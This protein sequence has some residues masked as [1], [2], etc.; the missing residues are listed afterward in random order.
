MRGCIKRMGK[1]LL[2]RKAPNPSLRLSFP[3]TKLQIA[4]GALGTERSLSKLSLKSGEL[5]LRERVMG[6][7]GD[8]CDWSDRYALRLTGLH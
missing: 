7:F 6:N 1:F 4:R 2:R 8:L 3:Q 5:F